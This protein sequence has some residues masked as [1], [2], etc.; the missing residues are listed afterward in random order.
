MSEAGVAGPDPHAFAALL[1]DWCLAV[2]PGDRVGVLSTTLACDLG[3][4]LH[5]AILARD[6]WPLVSLEPPS[7]AAERHLAARERHLTE[8]NPVELALVGALDALVRIHAPQST[9]ELADVDPARVAMLTRARQ[10]IQEAALALRWCATL[11]P[12][13]ALAQQAGMGTAAYATFVRRALF[14]DRPDPAGAWRELSERQALLVARLERARQIRIQAEGTDLTLSVAGRRW[15]NSDGR[16]NMPSGEVFT[17]PLERS[18]NGTISFSVPGGPRGSIV[19]GVRLTLKDGEVVEAHAQRGEQRLLAALATD[20]GARRLGELGIGTNT[21]I[22]R[23]T[24]EI[25]LDEKM[26]G[27]VHLALGRAYP[28]TGGINRSALHWDL[29]CDL[30]DGGRLTADGEPVVVDGALEA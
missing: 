12:T 7:L 26:A 20:E 14:L 16:R 11:S 21:G 22:D 18:A 27:T 13:P 29:I 3:A 15:V 6:A 5:S 24:G 28:E 25:L 8:P 30:R 17:A 1:C 9:T 19:S 4:A 2:S 23:P 10:P